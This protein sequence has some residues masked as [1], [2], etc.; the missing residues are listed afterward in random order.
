MEASLPDVSKAAIERAARAICA[1][2]G[3]NANALHQ[4][5]VFDG[6][7]PYD[8][9]DTQGRRYVYGWRTQE[10]AALAVLESIEDTVDVP[11]PEAEASFE[12]WWSADGL[13]IDPDS[14]DIPWYDKRKGLAAEAYFAGLSA[15]SK[16]VAEEEE[17]WRQ[18]PSRDE[19][20]NA[21]LDFAMTQLCDYLDI[22]T[23]TVNWDAA[24]ET[25]DGDVQAVLGNILRKH[26][27]DDLTKPSEIIPQWKPMADAPRDRPIILD[28]SYYYDSDE[29]PTEVF[30]VGEYVDNG[31]E[32]VWDIGDETH[33][34]DA[35]SG[36]LEIPKT[37]IKRDAPLFEPAKILK[38]MKLN[39][40]G[41]S[42]VVEE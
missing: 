13:F 5:N 39:R 30:A 9:E 1:S 33:R 35:P 24:T 11:S 32:Y 18:D 16:Q 3:I 41:T 31:T 36:W 8:Q 23:N 27:G 17:D 10:K 4:I 20:W 12:Q 22:D 40:D 25:L 6:T 34:L 26:F 19:R 29:S 14:A 7:E 2:K 42:A 28:L 37:A 15:G 21:G 38:R